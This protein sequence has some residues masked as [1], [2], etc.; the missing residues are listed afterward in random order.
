MSASDDERREESRGRLANVI[1]I[2]AG[3]AANPE[4]SPGDGDTLA[5]V[6]LIYVLACERV[7]G[8]GDT[9]VSDD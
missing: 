7:C 1:R 2:A 9:G 3:M 4:W 8:I 5:E 6:A